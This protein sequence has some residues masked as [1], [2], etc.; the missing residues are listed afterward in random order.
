MPFPF[1]LPTT[2]PISYPTFF[3]SPSHPSLPLLASS[4][5]GTLRNA[6]KAHKRLPPASQAANIPHIITLLTK[7]TTHLLT[8]T[9]ALEDNTAFLLPAAPQFTTSWR[10]T[11]TPPTRRGRLAG[12]SPRIARNGLSYEIFFTLSTLAYAHTLQALNQLHQVLASPSAAAAATPAPA[13]PQQLFNLAAANLLTA[14]SVYEHL[15]TRPRPPSAET[16]PVELTPPALAALSAV[17][18][19]D[20]TLVAVVKQD[21]YPTYVALTSTGGEA[22]KREK[23]RKGEVGVGVA[24]REWL[25]SPPAPPTSVRALLLARL[26]VA[27]SDHAGR[28]LGLLGGV[29]SVAVEFRAYVDALQRVARA[30]ACRFLGVDAEGA[31]RCG[32]GIAWVGLAREVLGGAGGGG[33]GGGGKDGVWGMDAGWA[34]EERVCKALESRWRKVNDSVLFQVV[35]GTAAVAARMPTGREIHSVGVWEAPRLGAE[36]MRALRMEGAVGVGMEGL[37]E[38]SGEEEEPAKVEYAGKGGYY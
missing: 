7:Y 13:D 30:K 23:R 29:E 6:L 12:E 4:H 21:P 35:P 20:A 24:S 2:S 16:W 14:A 18:M 10:A 33:G 15:L 31:G 17:N 38:D 32:E 28:A 34:E 19:A 5:R 1:T 3:T 25:Y 11:L 36:E 26:C 9:T 27:A 37:E 8:L 22:G